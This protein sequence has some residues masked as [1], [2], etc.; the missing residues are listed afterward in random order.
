MW[1]RIKAA[2][3]EIEACI[4]AQGLERV[5]IVSHGGPINALLRQFMGQPVE[6]LRTCWYDI[7]WSSTSCLRYR[8]GRRWVRW[9]NDARHIDALRGRLA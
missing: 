5:G 6:R 3:T 9:V 8:D 7:D 4:E 1:Q 2:W